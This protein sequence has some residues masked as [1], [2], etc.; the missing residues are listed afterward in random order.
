MTNDSKRAEIEADIAAERNALASSLS[1]LT[2]QFS[3]EGLVSSVGETIK[4]QSDELA[5]TVVRGARDNPAAVALVGAG[6]AWLLLGPKSEDGPSKPFD[7]RSNP[8]VGGFRHDAN[9]EEFEQRVDAAESALRTETSG[10]ETTGTRGFLDRSAAQ[11]RETLQEGT[12]KLTEAAKVRVIAARERAIIAQMELEAKADRI[13]AKGRSFFHDQPLLVGVE[14]AAVAAA[15]ALALPRTRTEDEAFGAHRD[16]LLS[17]ADR[18]LHDELRKAG[19][20][21]EAAV[22]EATDIVQEAV[23]SVPDGDDA[24]NQAEAEVRSA[25]KRVAERAKSA[26]TH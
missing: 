6:L 15:A 5:R 24:V 3:P 1:D 11:M 14:I 13:G 17:E 21:A 19:L 18:V 26:R 4:A 8:T 12:E 22:D 7:S 25:G 9:P 23:E 20:M 10:T 16:A 2:A